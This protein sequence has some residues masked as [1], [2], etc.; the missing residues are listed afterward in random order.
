M[1]FVVFRYRLAAPAAESSGIGGVQGSDGS[2]DA[3]SAA[4]QETTVARSR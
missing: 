4:E 1:T 3:G 2:A